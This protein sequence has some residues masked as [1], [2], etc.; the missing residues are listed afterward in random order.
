M[1]LTSNPEQEM[2]AAFI[3]RSVP[4]LLFCAMTTAQQLAN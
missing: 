2:V 4:S 3:T 1:K